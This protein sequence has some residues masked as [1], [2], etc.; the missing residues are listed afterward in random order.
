M[1]LGAP[2]RMVSIHQA[3]VD[4]GAGAWDDWAFKQPFV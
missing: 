4:T 3:V 2:A 1:R